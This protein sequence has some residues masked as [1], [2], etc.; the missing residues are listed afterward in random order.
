MNGFEQPN[1]SY[2]IF[3]TDRIEGLIS[4]LYAKEY[5]IV[6]IKTYYKESFGDSIIAFGR[7]DND[8]LRKDTLFL[9]NHFGES[10]AIIKYSEETEIKKIFSNGAESPMNMLMYNTDSEKISYIYEGVSFS[11]EEKARYWMPSKKEDFKAGM[12]V[13]YLNNNRWSERI[14][15]NP[16]E[17]WEKAYKLLTKYEKVRVACKKMQTT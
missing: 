9:L 15:E 11:F 7:F 1:T 13:E 6:P 14:V 17:E 2:A 4:V 16:S 8:T 3:S 12:V 10:S 5:Q